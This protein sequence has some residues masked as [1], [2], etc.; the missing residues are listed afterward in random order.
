MTVRYAAI[1]ND[2]RARPPS[3]DVEAA[4]RHANGAT[5]SDVPLENLQ[6]TKAKRKVCSAERLA[7]LLDTHR[8]GQR[9]PKRRPT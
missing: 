4:H 7:A 1:W 2:K 5:G 6:S 3:G 9:R 8:W